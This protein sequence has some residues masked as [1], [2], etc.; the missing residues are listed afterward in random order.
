MAQNIFAA[1]GI[2][3]A[4]GVAAIGYFQWRTAHQR[5][6]SDLFERRFEAYEQIRRAI[7][8]YAPMLQVTNET[9]KLFITAQTRA[10]FLF[11]DEVLVYLEARYKDLVTV[12][13]FRGLTPTPTQDYQD[14]QRELHDA[15]RRLVALPT[16]LDALLIPY[17][18]MNQKMPSLW[19]PF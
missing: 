7:F 11:G 5:I 8:D 14:Q 15:D 9:L 3:I 18:R 2:V 4:F 13:T 12:N 17:M 1:I 19:W 16:E 6:I 10:K